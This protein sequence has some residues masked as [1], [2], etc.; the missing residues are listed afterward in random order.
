MQLKHLTTV[1]QPQD[2]AAKI[3][4]LAWSPSN[5]KLAVSTAD[6]AIL[7][8]D[9]AGERK[10]KFYTKP[11][12]AKYGK[13]SY[14]VR[15]LAFS[16]DSTK[17]AVGQTDN[18][19]YVYKIGEDW[20]EKKV[21][22]N[23][24]VQ[25]AAVTCLIW[26][27]E[28][29]IVFGLADGK[30]RAANVKTG[31][32]QTLFGTNSF[33]CALAPSPNGRGFL[34]GHADGAV[35]RC[36]VAEDEN[37][38]QQGK[39]LNHSSPPYAIAWTVN[40]VI[41]AGCDKKVVF[42]TPEGRVSQTFDHSRDP[43][44]KDFTTAICSPSGQA[45]IL[46]SFDRLRVFIYSPRKKMWEETKPKEIAHLYT[47]TALAWK[48]DGSR[49]VAGTLC[50]G[51]EMFD[52]VLKRSVW[53]NKWEMRF[54][55][56]SQVLL[57]PLQGGGR[58]V[59][60]KSQYGYEIEEVKI[61]GQERFVMA[62]TPETLLL[63]DLQKNLLSEVNWKNTG[64]NEKL[65][66]DND[67]VCMIFNAGELSLVEYGS[68]EILGSVRTEF[69]NPHLISVRINERKE[70]GTEENKKMAYL[71]DLKTIRV[72]DLL[73]GV[74]VAEVTH[75]SK[76]DW[77]ELNETGRKLLF[78]DK[79]LNLNLY[80][81]ETQQKTS[82][83][84]YCTFVSWVF[85]SD[86]VVAQNRDN[87]CVWYNIES[88]E[89]VT[90]VPIKGEVVSV[91]REGGRT[92]VVIQEGSHQS[93]V[94]LDEGLVEFRTAVDDGDFGRAVAFLE[95]LD[96][97]PEAEAMWRTLARI[98]LESA[99]FAYAERCFSALGDVSKAK[100][101]RGINDLAERKQAETGIPGF[102]HYEVRARLAVL[103]RDFTL[104]ANIYLEQDEVDTA[105]Q[106]F[107]NLHKFDEA[108]ALAEA[109][110]LPQLESLKAE[111][112]RWLLETGQEERAGEIME[113]E[114][115]VRTAVEMYLKAGLPAK[116]ARAVARHAE[117]S[118]DSDLVQHV[119]NALLNGEFHERA[120]DL[121]ES[122][123]SDEKALDCYRKGQVFSRAVE[124]ARDRFPA[125]VVNLEEEWGDHLAQ[126]KQMDAAV[127]HYIEAGKTVKA[128]DAAIAGRQWKRAAQIIQV[129]QDP[130]ILQ[131][132]Y[133]KLAQHFAS[134]GEYGQAEDFYLKGGLHREAIEMYNGVG[135][136]EQAHQLAFKY[137]RADEVAEMY[138]RQAQDMEEQGK[139]RDAERLYIAVAEPDLAITMY[140]NQRQYDQML[141]LVQEHHP[142]LVQSTHMHLAKELESEGAYSQAEQHYIK[143]GDWKTAVNMYRGAEIWEDAHRVAKEHGG[144]NA[145]KQ[146]AFLWAK[147]LGGDSAVK[148][149]NKFGLLEQCID[150]ACDNYIFDFAF[151]LA[152]AASKEKVLDVH[153]KYAMALEDEGKFKEAEIEFIKADKPK[154][155]VLMYVHNQ[156]WESAQRVAEKHDPDSVTDVLVGQAKM[157]FQNKDFMRFESL[158]L[159]AQKPE[160][161]IKLYRESGMWS[162][163][164]RLCKEYLPHRLQQLQDEFDR[165]NTA[166]S[167]GRGGMDTS[168]LVGKARELEAN[169]EYARAIDC[170]L[171]ANL[172]E[173]GDQESVDRCWVRAGEI[174]LKFLDQDRASDVVRSAALKLNQQSNFNAAAQ[175]Y[176]G[177]D[178]IR[179]AIDSLI[180]GEEWAKAK[181]IAQELDPS[182]EQY[183]DSKYKDFLKHS[184]KTDQLASVDLI[185]AL[186]VYAE[187]GNW[188]K[189]LEV[190]KGHGPMVLHKYLAQYTTNLIRENRTVEALKM[191]NKYGA[192]A[193][194]Q[195]FNIYKKITVDL[196]NMRDLHNAEAYSTWCLLRDM[197]YDVRENV[198]KD[199]GVTVFGPDLVSQLETTLLVAHY[200]ANRSVFMGNKALQ[201]LAVK[202]SVAL[203]RYTDIV[204]A[205]KAFYEAG[206]DCKKIGWENMGFVFL[207]RYLDLCEAIEEGSL[208]MLDSSDFEGTDIP[209]EIPLPERMHLDER[210]HEDI[211][212]WVLAVSMDQKLERVLPL[213]ERMAYEASLVS[214][215]EPPCP[216]CLVTGYPVLRNKVEFSG[217]EK[218]FANKEDWNK[219]LME[220]KMSH[221]GDCQDMLKFLGKCYGAS[222]AKMAAN[223]VL[224]KLRRLD[225]YPK[226]IEDFRIRTF[227]GATVTLVSAI[228]MA[229]LFVSELSDYL[230][231]DV[232]ERLFV[233][234]SRG[235]K[236]IINFDFVFHRLGCDYVSLDALDNSGDQQTNVLHNVYKQRLD[237]NGNPIQNPESYDV[238]SAVAVTTTTPKCGSCYGAETKEMPCCNTCD[239]VKL[240]YRVRGWAIS[241]L[242]EIE[243]CK[244][245]ADAIALQRALSE[246]CQLRGNLEVNRVGGNFHFA[247]GKSFVHD[248]IHVHNLEALSLGDVNLT[249]TIRHLSF[250]MNI[251]G[252]TNPLDGTHHVAL[253]SAMMYNYYLKIIPT[254]YQKLDS[255]FI[256]TN[257]F[258]VTLNAKGRSD[259]QGIPGVFFSYDFSPLMVKYSEKSKSFGHFA[260]GVCAIIGGVFTVAGLLDAFIYRSTNALKKKV[261]LG[262]AG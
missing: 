123:G 194:T 178:M 36:Y 63:G 150:F 160:T 29:P 227:G 108:V 6:R 118:N 56:P 130:E 109:R 217:G 86:V 199:G 141:R 225:A 106:M 205:D 172:A 40:S 155:A 126:N 39:I 247:P 20:G 193:F 183:V 98:S 70:R 60:L 125:E 16:P 68:N 51:V 228:V 94:I 256:E 202:C 232:E 181:K 215:N 121:F 111:H 9:D 4:A 120:G 156:D 41:V 95:M 3:T 50:G 30:V 10:D 34:S 198:R 240:A 206:I 116:A 67:N 75:E 262:K 226:T 147:F 154:E 168:T 91:E 260:V 32:S 69:M 84:N 171:Q 47:I 71:L 137:L 104:A 52:T 218:M 133:G 140:K 105:L 66:F 207:N 235:K 186:D 211:K 26:P 115:D 107:R 42:Y 54:V 61:M 114:G 89:R 132:Y 158:M 248:H 143:A 257:Q 167:R 219:V 161:A 21:I 142:D 112:G 165:E 162:E 249:H 253:D 18:I 238:G 254:M 244:D 122:I 188:E 93:S 19:V 58:G 90:V 187:Q 220:A 173:V 200:Y 57:I 153:Y 151:D 49:V 33:V 169:G 1:L 145:G 127:N 73:Y 38:M 192:P 135:H 62:R 246:G 100:M 43:T 252:K 72:V 124:L 44:E 258:S 31:K 224:E 23:K 88:P 243:Q 15:G 222:G 242:G 99:Q 27:L 17:I 53:N 251:P 229:L 214:P 74:S 201:L 113:E 134:I 237:L 131:K 83:L 195:N 259:S 148:L 87:L 204:P 48:R 78:R 190:A 221:S 179:E 92:E 185:G 79:R 261:E 136:W 24:F 45:V 163:A 196:F 182:F 191:Y 25:A 149:L 166:S 77:L 2:G 216:P 81:L 102:E 8:F 175:L 117:L 82:I 164:L 152:K 184:G 174:A 157:A 210:E 234:T 128:L 64:G 180:Q 37:P 241:R 177:A 12:D 212:E 208:D 144:P 197:L 35:V 239:Q 250:G 138:I 101:L 213:D 22:C 11:A 176:L 170:Y 146:V 209:M 255:S 245:T 129:I 230:R 14:H 103:E 119:A 28:G 65:Y 233:D 59:S 110:N 85:G 139:L 97:T 13:K 96:M 236:L 80:D 7:L 203:L 76:I 46:G 5:H 223:D 231:T 189:C 55:G 159:R